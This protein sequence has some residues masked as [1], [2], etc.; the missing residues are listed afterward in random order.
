[1][2]TRNAT[3]I[4]PPPSIYLHQISLMI[5]RIQ[6]IWLLLAALA[7]FLTIRI[8]FYSGTDSVSLEFRELTGTTSLIILILS[9][10]IGTCSVI[11]I[12]FFKNRKVQMRLVLLCIV[13]ECLVLYLYIRQVALFDKGNLAIGSFLHPII[14]IFLI[15][16]AIGIYKD[17][18]L[19]KESNRLR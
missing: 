5:Q 2:S 11:S 18:K 3:L 10:A 12:F 14:I 17:S 15:L 13:I 1:M 6:T 8:P 9:S 16:A 19:I 7:I 4:I